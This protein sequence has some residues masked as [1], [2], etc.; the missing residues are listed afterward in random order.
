MQ[1]TDYIQVGIGENSR[2]IDEVFLFVSVD[3]TG[4]GIVAQS[5]EMMGEHFFMPFVAAD[6]G[7]VADLRKLAMHLSEMTGKEIKLVKFSQRQD[8]EVL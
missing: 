1:V 2:K 7:R 5:M 8:M 3:D 6:L 4:E